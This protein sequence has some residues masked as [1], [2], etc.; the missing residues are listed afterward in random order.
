MASIW[1]GWGG[2]RRV[3]LAAQ[4]AC[5][6]QRCPGHLNRWW[7]LPPH[8]RPAATYLLGMALNVSESHGNAAG[9]LEVGLRPFWYFK[10]GR[11]RVATGRASALLSVGRDTVDPA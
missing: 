3:P 6:S 2:P 9:R 5:Q 4:T 7:C 10:W 11:F 1:V 8:S